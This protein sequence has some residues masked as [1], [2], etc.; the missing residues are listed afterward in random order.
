VPHFLQAFD[1]LVKFHSKTDPLSNDL[2][3][4]TDI[5]FRVLPDVRSS[6]I[7]F[8]LQLIHVCMWLSR[9]VIEKHDKPRGQTCCP[10]AVPA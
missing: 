3:H 6:D 9:R 5:A 8:G 1:L 10:L 2:G 4:F 7:S